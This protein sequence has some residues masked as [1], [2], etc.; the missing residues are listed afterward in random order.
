MR[1]ASVS[2]A[3]LIGVS[4]M[5]N[6]SMAATNTAPA[7]ATSAAA[8]TTA[9]SP[10][11]TAATNSCAA[12][13]TYSELQKAL[14]DARAAANG[15]LNNDMWGSLV[16]RDGTVCAV[17]YTGDTVDAQWP[18]S[19]VIAAQKANTANAFSVKGNALSTANLYAGTQPG[20]FLFGLQDSNPVDVKVAYAG[21][22]ADYGSS[23]D[24]MVGKVVGGVNVFG[25]GNAL[26]NDKGEIVGA[27]G[28]SGDTSC[29]DNNIAWRARHALKLDYVPSGVSKDKT[30]AIIYD[31]KLG[32]SSSG[33]GHP[34][35]GGTEDKVAGNL[36]PVEKREGAATSDIAKKA[37][38]SD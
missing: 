28:V 20:G 33:F 4:I 17:A 38:K 3:A 9:A 24:P 16:A 32:K 35:C 36:P 1:F 15:G 30:D 14:K 25:G 37:V 34:T 2:F 26:Y 11:V 7:T 13:P 6:I 31:I 21:P 22:A 8:T 19:R 29:A 5:S 12:L 23:K 27:L 18:G 10:V